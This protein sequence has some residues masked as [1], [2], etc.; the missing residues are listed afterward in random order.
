VGG[1]RSVYP[2]VTPAYNADAEGL[3]EAAEVVFTCKKD[4]DA[5]KVRMC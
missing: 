3:S 2:E 5:N 4:R 1:L